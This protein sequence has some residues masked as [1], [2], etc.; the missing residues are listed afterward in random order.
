M[1]IV[2]HRLF[3][4]DDT[5]IR[6]RESPNRGG[7]IANIR[8]LVMHYTAGPSAEHSVNWLVNSTAKASAHL[9]I[10]RD[11]SIT[12]LVPFDTV[13]WHAGQSEWQGVVG[14]NNSSIGIELDNAGSLEKAGNGWRAWFGTV[15]PPE[16]VI[17]AIHKNET[18]IRAWHLYTPEQLYVALEVSALLVNTYKLL[19]VLGHDDIA[20][21]RKADPGPAFPMETFRSRLFGRYEDK[22]DVNLYE[23]TA[24]LNI[25]VGPNTTFQSLAISPLPRGTRLQATGQENGI[26][27]EVDI[28]GEIKGVSGARGWVHRGYVRPIG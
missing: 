21:G 5:P 27:K 20:P 25:R 4:D 28:V 1:K 22:P 26:W 18:N 2:N 23:T 19:D 14:L 3:N 10:G 11:G 6:Y 13:A 24:N 15:Y 8:Y 17:E 9:V 7:K 12:Q 16:Q